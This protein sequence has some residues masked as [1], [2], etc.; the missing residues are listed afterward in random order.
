MTKLLL[1]LFIKDYNNTESILVHSAIGKLAGITGIVCNILLFLGKLIVGLIADSVSIIADAVNN[2]SDASSSVVTLLGFQMA[3]QP[4]DAD[5]PYGHARYE[6][7]SGLVVAA[8]ILLIGVDLA[9]SSV[10]K[11]IHPATVEFSI[12]TFIVLLVSIGLKLWMSAFFSSLGKHIH[13]TTLQATSMD[14]RNDVIASS[15][16]LIGCLIEYFFHLNIDG[17][18]GLIVAIFIL[19]SGFNIAKETISPLLGKQADPELVE[20]ISQLVLSHE[21]ILGI[22]DLLVHDYGPGQCFA[23]VHVELSAE[24]D[25]LACHEIIDEIEC[26]ALEKM[27]VHLVIHYDPVVLN[28]EEWSEMRQIVD[29]I[30]HNLDP[31]LSM[32]DFRIVRGSKQ[33]RLVFDLAVPYSMREKQKELEQKIEEA[34]LSKGKQYVTI[35][36]FDGKA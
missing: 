10:K 8:L 2:L 30:I 16:V 36:R 13:S 17:Y 1:R 25:P 29:E 6:Y 27:N 32:H 22:H 11:I 21:K 33:T 20:K 26:D 7:L 3:Q 18:V 19:Y 34:L 12:I 15:A 14:S 5:H 9:K 24:E 28:D 4:A 23:S 35:I 31:Q